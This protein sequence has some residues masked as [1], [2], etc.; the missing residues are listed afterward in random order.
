MKI[1]LT[2]HAKERIKE[3]D[4]ALAQIR[5]ALD[6]PD[7]QHPARQRNRIMVYKTIG[8]K[9]LKVVFEQLDEMHLRIITA[10]WKG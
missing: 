4:I 6:K 5:Q 1:L 10:M 3:R 7:I 8:T 9:Q 2:D